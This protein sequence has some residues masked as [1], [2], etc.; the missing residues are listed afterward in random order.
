VERKG[1]G[2]PDSIYD[3][4]AEEVS[5]ALSRAYC[6][7]FG[8]ILHHNV[9]KVLLRGGAAMPRFGGRD[10][11]A[12]IDIYV[13]GR[14]VSEFEGMPVPVEAITLDT[15]RAWFERHLPW[16][17]P[18]RQVSTHCLMRPSSTYLADLFRRK[19]ARGRPW[20]MTRRSA[21]G[22]PRSARPKPRCWA[23]TPVEEAAT[24]CSHLRVSVDVNVADDEPSGSV[25]QTVTGTSA[26][27]GD[28]GEAG[29]GNRVNGLITPTG[30]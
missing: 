11:L 23:P 17:D 15:C 9:D 7:M 14:A 10:L 4:L 8:V 24:S 2:H 1:A 30:R 25:F 29:R 3:A 5:L 27:A 28:D 20:P 19:A 18:I 6:E 21:S 13:A 12:P 22:S 26:E 16:V